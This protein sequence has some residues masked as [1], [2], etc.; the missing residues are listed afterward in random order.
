M[1]AAINDALRLIALAK[2]KVNTALLEPSNIELM[3]ALDYLNEAI[4]KLACPSST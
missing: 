2:E 4:D 1:E 3:N